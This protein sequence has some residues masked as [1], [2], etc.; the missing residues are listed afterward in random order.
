MPPIQPARDTDRGFSGVSLTFARQPIA[1]TPDDLAGVDV[2]VLGAPF[3]LAVT[4]RTGTRFGPR[5]VRLAEDVGVDGRPSIELG[6]DPYEE[7]KVVDYGDADAPAERR[8][9]RARVHPGARRRDPRGGRDPGSDRRRPLDHPADPARTGRAPRRR[10]LQRHPLRHARRHRR[11]LRGRLAARPR[12]AVLARRR[13]RRAARRQ[14]RAD[15]P[16]RLLAVPRGVRPHAR[17]GLPLVHDGPDRR[18]RPARRARR[19]DR[20]RP[21]ARA[22]HLP[23]GRRRLDGPGLRARHRHARA[24][25]AHVARAARARCGAS[26]ASSTSAASTSSRS[27]RPTTSPASRRSPA[28]A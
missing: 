25:R 8:P 13:G 4:Y 26:P 1:L 19:D 11:D 17:A 14:H 6:I 12:P 23:H 18:A 27:R 21:R 24:G 20:A 9:R 10:R 7:L 22:A 3:D 2:A 15:R 16:A 5:A 28:S